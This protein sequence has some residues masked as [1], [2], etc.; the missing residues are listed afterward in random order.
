MKSPGKESGRLA[1]FNANPA[2]R[3]KCRGK[4]GSRW[5]EVALAEQRWAGALL[6]WRMFLVGWKG[7]DK[8]AD[9]KTISSPRGGGKESAGEADRLREL[10]W[11]DMDTIQTQR[12]HR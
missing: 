9:P 1:H 2:I 10:A 11:V 6:P 7:R 3:L 5:M 8:P 4:G 12:E